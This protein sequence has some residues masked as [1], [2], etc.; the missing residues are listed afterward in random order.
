M[1]V[2]EPL[3]T[4]VMEWRYRG[5]VRQEHE[6]RCVECGKFLSH[7]V[8]VIYADPRDGGVESG[9]RA[10]GVQIQAGALGKCLRCKTEN[11]QILLSV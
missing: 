8:I 10:S 5:C 7:V 3:Q 6:V 1:T 2:R 11:T 4:H 9:L